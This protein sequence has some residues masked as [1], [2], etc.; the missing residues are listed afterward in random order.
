MSADPRAYAGHGIRFTGQSIN[1]R[2]GKP[3]PPEAWDW[4]EKSPR[5]CP[6]SPARSDYKPGSNRPAS[7]SLDA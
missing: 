6:S 1:N 2:N 5:K 4:F 3:P 7:V